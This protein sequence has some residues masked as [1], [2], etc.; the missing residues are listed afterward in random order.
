M[1]DRKFSPYGHIVALAISAGVAGGIMPALAG[2]VMADPALWALVIIGTAV[3]VAA[4]CRLAISITGKLKILWIL[5]ALASVGWL[6][7]VG[8][9]ISHQGRL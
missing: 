4:A 1:N 6:L 9:T 5:A 7:F 8:V 3:G 2:P